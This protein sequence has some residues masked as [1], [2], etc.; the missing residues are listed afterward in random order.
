MLLVIQYTRVF[1]CICNWDPS[2][3][4]IYIPPPKRWCSHLHQRWIAGSRAPIDSITSL[5]D[6]L[7]GGEGGTTG[8]GSKYLQKPKCEYNP[9]SRLYDLLA[10]L[11]DVCTS[12]DEDIIT[13]YS[14]VIIANSLLNIQPPE[15]SPTAH[16]C[17]QTG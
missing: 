15:R 11:L 10:G 3:G 5:V 13:G 6:C 8:E 4:Y 16:T 12:A 9:T 17:G 7:R 1:M 14:P 2:I